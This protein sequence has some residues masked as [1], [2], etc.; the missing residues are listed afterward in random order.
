MYPSQTVHPLMCATPGFKFA[1]LQ[2]RMAHNLRS[3][4]AR[5]GSHGPIRGAFSSDGI[6]PIGYSDCQIER[7]SAGRIIS[8]YPI[9]KE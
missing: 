5:E 2:S 6:T 4:L 8:I 1:G 9:P 3:V 7:N